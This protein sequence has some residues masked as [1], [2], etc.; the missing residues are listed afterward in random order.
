MFPAVKKLLQ[1]VFG[2]SA[3]TDM[4]ADHDVTEPPV[5]AAASDWP[6]LSKDAIVR[7]LEDSRSGHPDQMWLDRSLVF[8]N[9]IWPAMELV[10]QKKGEPMS[11]A[12]YRAMS[13]LEGMEVFVTENADAPEAAAVQR[14]VTRLPGYAIEGHREQ[15]ERH[16]GYTEIQVTYWLDEMKAGRTLPLPSR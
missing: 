4:P 15:M 12:L 11:E 10:A 14:Y 5:P 13:T 16:H 6:L 3:R 8:I 2:G 9:A 7:I 1:K